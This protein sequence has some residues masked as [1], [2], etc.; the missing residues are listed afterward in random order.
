MKMPGLSCWSATSCCDI[1]VFTSTQS[2]RTFLGDRHFL[3]QITYV[4]RGWSMALNVTPLVILF[5]L[6]LVLVGR[7]DDQQPQQT[8]M[9]VSMC[10]LAIRSGSSNRRSG[11]QTNQLCETGCE[12]WAQA[13]MK[14]AP[15]STESIEDIAAQRSLLWPWPSAFLSEWPP[16][17]RQ[18]RRGALHA[19][20]SKPRDWVSWHESLSS[21]GHPCAATSWSHA[22]TQLFEGH[23]FGALRRLSVARSK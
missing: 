3:S 20:N 18:I 11:L 1:S 17:V 12:G 13:A 23:C 8:A 7:T 19:E 5:G 6:V 22:G 15:S 10:V 16:A 9:N 21:F 2:A 4:D 14:Q